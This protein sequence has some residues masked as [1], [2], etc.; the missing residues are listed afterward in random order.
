M[1]KVIDDKVYIK[2][3]DDEALGAELLFAN[4]MPFEMSAGDILTFTVREF[5]DKASPVIF[6]SKSVPGGTRIVIRHAD[7]TDAAYGQYSADLQLT[8]SDNMTKTVWPDIDEENPPSPYTLD[9]NIGNFII[10]PEVT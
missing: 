3:G 4:G 10:L 5:P 1:L 2:R 6:Q 8:T 7:T 9:E